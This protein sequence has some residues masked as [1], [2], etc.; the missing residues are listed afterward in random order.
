MKRKKRRK[1]RRPRASNG[2]RYPKMCTAEHGGEFPSVRGGQ[3]LSKGRQGLGERGGW[4]E[5]TWDPLPKRQYRSKTMIIRGILS[6][7]FLEQ[8]LG[9]HTMTV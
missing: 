2:Q 8:A 1:K 7:F 9:S 3:G 6:I 4:L 5:A